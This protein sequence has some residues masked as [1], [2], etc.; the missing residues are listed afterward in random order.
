MRQTETILLMMALAFF[1]NGCQQHTL[2]I[3]TPDNKNFQN[4]GRTDRLSDGDVVLIGSASSVTLRFTGDSCNVSLKIGKSGSDYNYVSIAVDSVYLTKLKIASDTATWY[5]I[6]V[7]GTAKEHTV[8]VY[9]STE[10]MIGDIIF[11][12]AEV[13]NLLLPPALPEK[14]IEFIGNSI[15]CGVGI[16]WKLIPCGSGEYQ[17][18]HNSYWAYGPRVARAL[19][20]QFM[21]SSVSGIG[22]YR[23]WNMTGPSMPQVYGNRYLNTDST[24]R[25]DFSRFRPDVVSICLGTNDMSEGDTIHARKSF[26]PEMFVS[27]YISFVDTIYKYYPGVQVALLNS[28][29]LDSTKNAV[30]MDCLHKVADHFNEKPVVQPIRVFEFHDIQGHGCGG[31]P[32]K[33]DQAKMA[34]ELVPFFRQLLNE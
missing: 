1:S 22:I 9:K 18:Q 34:G 15:T 2:K 11:G 23:T 3:F 28:P 10:S 13:D 27:H 25:W 19:H 24:K 12:G 29:M 30:L 31:H 7:T 32:D 33:D 5:H 20:T 14:K 17:D 16:D 4:A 26:N 8:T 21:L 6:P